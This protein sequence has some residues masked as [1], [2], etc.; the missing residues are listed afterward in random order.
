MG[1]GISSVSDDVDTTRIIITLVFMLL[2]CR[3]LP[4]LQLT[5]STMVGI[6]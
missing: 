3:R 5:N 4:C 2:I 6:S 1:D